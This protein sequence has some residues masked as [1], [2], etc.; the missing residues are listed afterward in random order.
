MSARS[1]EQISPAAINVLFQRMAAIR[2][3]A[4]IAAALLLLAVAIHP[5]EAQ[6]ITGHICPHSHDDGLSH[7]I[8]AYT[9]DCRTI[10]Q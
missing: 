3:A 10:I 7:E 6:I 8:T 9:S 1:L 5:V 2:L 4:L